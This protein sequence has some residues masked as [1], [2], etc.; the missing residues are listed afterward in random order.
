MFA[1]ADRTSRLTATKTE[2]TRLVFNSFCPTASIDQGR[3]NFMPQQGTAQA[4]PSS[5]PTPLDPPQTF[6]AS[7]GCRFSTCFRY[8]PVLLLECF[9]NISGVPTTT[10][11]PPQRDPK[12][13]NKQCCNHAHWLFLGL[14]RPWHW[15]SR[16]AVASR[17]LCR[18]V[19]H[20]LCI[21]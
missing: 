21:G 15:R 16:I 12:E 8:G 20:Q 11:S 13:E 17:V 19:C 9:G 18:I 7:G 6:T 3:Q 14:G 10:I 1:L 4:A 5:S 2:Q